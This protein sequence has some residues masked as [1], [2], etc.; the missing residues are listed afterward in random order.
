MFASKVESVLKSIPTILLCVDLS[1]TDSLLLA[2]ILLF[3]NHEG[4]GEVMDI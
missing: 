2:K 1:V 3:Y 4:R